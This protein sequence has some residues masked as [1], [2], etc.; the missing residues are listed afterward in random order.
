[1]SVYIV[2]KLVKQNK[3]YFSY[4]N[5]YSYY[6]NRMFSC[7]VHLTVLRSSNRCTLLWLRGSFHS[8]Y[9]FISELGVSREVLVDIYESC[10]HFSS[11]KSKIYRD[12][13]QTIINKVFVKITGHW[14]LI[15]FFQPKISKKFKINCSCFRKFYDFLG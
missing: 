5:R 3:S 2:F 13:F 10:F 12:T 11:K 14:N 15:F 8:R 9:D 7:Y 6:A 4:I 1:M